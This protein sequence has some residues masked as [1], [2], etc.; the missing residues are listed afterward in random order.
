MYL[1]YKLFN[2]LQK[3]QLYSYDGDDLTA[4]NK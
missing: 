4:F 1:N 3:K 2:W